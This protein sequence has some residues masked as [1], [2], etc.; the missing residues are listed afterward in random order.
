TPDAEALVFGEQRLSYAQL[1]ARANQ[2]AH[3]LIGQGVGPDVL[4]GIAAERSV[5]MVVGL[6]AILKAGGAYV[7]LDPEYPSERLSYMFED[8]GIALLLTQSHLQLPLPAGL[9]VLLLDQLALDGYPAHAPAVAVSP[10]NLAYVIYTSGSTGK[11][12]GAGNRHSALTNRLCWMQQ[13]YGLDGSDTVLQKTPFSFDVSVWEFFWPL[14]TG[15]RLAVAGPGDHRDPSRLVELINAH[16]VTTLHFVPSML[17]VFLQDAQVG[18]CTGLAR[19]V[20]SGEAL[21]VDA[22]QQV[23]AKLPQAGLYNLYGPTEAAID[24]THW[25]CRE[26]GADTVPIGQPIANLATYVLDAELNPVPVGVIGELYLGGAGLARGYHRRPALTAERFATSPF[27]SGERLYRTGDLARQR[28]DGVIEYAG[29]IDHQVKIR[30]LRIEL[31]EIEARLME[32]AQ[33]REAVVLALDI[34]GS[35]QL[36]GYLVPQDGVDTHNL[37]DTL[38]AS[39]LAQLPDYMVPSH[40][41]LLAELP[42]SPNG[43]LERKA[44]PRPDV[45]QA[46][47]AYVAPQT[48]LEHELAALWQEV[49]QVER[50]GTSDNFFELGGDSI[51]SIQLVSRARQAGIRFSPKALFE[52]P[53]IQALAQVAERGASAAVAEQGPLLGVTPLLPF[54]KV[55]FDTAIPERQHW[56]QS[57][58]LQPTEVLD[59]TMLQ[60]ALD[61]LV[62]QHDALR[63]RFT[64]VD[65]QWQANCDAPG[66]AASLTCVSLADLDALG[67]HADA[68]QRSLDLS[69]G[70]LFKALLATCGEAGQRLLLVAHHLVVDG[71]SWRI[72][73]EDLQQACRQ[74]AKGLAPG[75]AAR[76]TSVRGWAEY[77]QSHARDTQE[78]TLAHWRGLLEGRDGDLPQAR[79]GASLQRQLARSCVS[80]FDAELTRQLLQHAGSAYRTQVNDLLLTALAQVIARWT[81]REDVLVQLEGHGREVPSEAFDLSRTVGWFTSLYPVRLSVGADQPG[82]IKQVK[83]Q[84]RAL[85]GN[86]LDF[87]AA[88]YLGSA[89][90]REALAE[91]PVPRI[92]FNYLGQFDSSFAQQGGLFELA[93]EARGEELSALAPLGNWLSIDGG[94]QGG[95]L[96]LAWTFSAAMFDETTIAALASDY[97]RTLRL[98]VEHCLQP[99]VRGVTPSDFPLAGLDQAGLERLDLP[100]ARLDDLFPLSPMQQGMLFHTL[101]HKAAGDYI[102]QMRLDVEGL[103]PERFVQAWQCALDHHDSLRSG[104]LWQGEL[105]RP[106]QMVLRDCALPWRLIDWRGRDDLAT[107]LDSLAAAERAQG[108]VLDQAPLLR[109]VL[110]RTGNDRHQ[111]IY[112]CHHILMDGWSVS[113]LLAEVLQRYAGQPPQRSVG[114]YRDYIAWLQ[115]RDVQATETFWKAQ[116]RTLEAPTRL[117][118]VFGAASVQAA[119]VPQQSLQVPL[120]AS[121]S[122]QLQAFARSQQVTVNTLLQAAWLL[123]LQ[124]YTGQA[125]VCFGATVA[126]R[127]A[128]V[129]GAMEQIGLFINTL[130]VIASPR[131]Q[132]PVGEFLRALQ[133]SNLDLREHEHTPLYELQRWAGQGAQALFDSLLVF[134]NYPVSAALAE[135]SPQGP[136]FTLLANHEQTNYPLV[137]AVNLG[138][139]LHLQYSH[140]PQLFDGATVAQLNRHLLHLLTQLC[141][142]GARRLG[143]LNLLPVA[144]RDQLLHCWTPCAEGQPLVHQRI[145]QWA[146]ETPDAVALHAGDDTVTYGQLDARANALAHALLARGIKAEDRLGVAMPR[147]AELIV[148]LL[149]VHK[150]G[151]AYVPLDPEYPAERLAY[152]M[153]DS[154]MVLLLSDSRLQG[155]PVPDG[156]AVLHPD[157]LDLSALPCT[158]PAVAVLP[159]QLAYVIYT[160]GSTGQ[161]KGVAVE[162]GP[163]AMH[164]R[165]IGQRYEMT[166]EDC[167]LH[168]MSFAF[169]G[170]HERWLTSLTHGGRLLIRDD[171]LWTAQKTYEQMHRFG[172]SVAAFPPLYLLQLAEHAERDGNPPPVRVYCFGGDAVPNASF[173]LARRALRPRYII[174]GYGP[175]ET[176]VTPLIWKAGREDSCGAAYAPIGTRIGQRSAQVLDADLDLLPVGLPGE[177]Y[178]GGSGV[179]RGYLDRPGLTAERFVPDPFGDGARVYRSGDLVRQRSDGVVDYL[180]RIDHQVKIRG[181]RIE[182][183]EI[184]ASLQAQPLVRE[185]VVL[186]RDGGTGPQLVGYLLPEDSAALQPG[187]TQSEQREAIR[188][189]LKRQLPAYMVPSHLVFL[190]RFPLTPNGKLDRKGLPAPDSLQGSEAFQAPSSELQQQVAG[191]WQEVLKVE[192]VGLGDNFF[193]LGGHSLL[194]TQATAQ[195][196]LLLGGEVALELLFASASLADYAEAVAATLNTHSED[197]LSDMFD[198]M[199]ELEAN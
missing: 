149:A 152:L 176:V 38:K 4:V 55:F 191:V 32:Q 173:E 58:L 37:R 43:K 114:R 96:S 112:T 162:H 16:R 89:S 123:L 180:G 41:V 75:L 95:E 36:V 143:E 125:T 45:S 84:L 113:R 181:F 13:A 166:P 107:S 163:L 71:V 92:T 50:V 193:E 30:G 116:L 34:L 142:D 47:A 159:A 111:L 15:A 170:A 98:L 14:M 81:G 78:A 40:W 127:P 147:S 128:Q 182:L 101:Y 21:P 57:V 169:D 140:D 52:Q 17:Q 54:Q 106:L 137:L 27:G 12:K 126:G 44:L 199:A 156:L 5:E 23:F 124:R 29:R 56:N 185:A 85:P 183:G 100:L 79:V 76:S 35:Q 2:L 62:E 153:R 196:Q 117:A 134:E 104:F 51:V 87:A 28:A 93:R 49:L 80:R 63:L 110:V 150:A 179:A 69:E 105:E 198:F 11:P 120:D 135:A 97:E 139:T 33:V 77:L 8:S 83:E 167:E 148:C 99:G 122:A 144:E 146:R 177:L 157:R 189:A 161:P 190:E 115:E 59:A 53:T 94:V 88:R 184:E 60:Q 48:P 6:L 132:Q 109:L 154:A 68:L 25:T 131:P 46:Q 133:A 1:D 31:G 20:C 26:E 18:S 74:L 119:P 145:A 70:P 91:L 121:Y 64:E 186:A 187:A 73:L 72:L 86:G 178:L 67:S 175:T 168:F 129:K 195:L 155:L 19:I 108:F 103:D 174:N 24:V 151:A 118:D 164:C 10:E 3:C 65:G 82:S 192:R 165:A 39:L 90:V 138:Q 66:Q 171:S 188:L 158:A 160:S 197:D 22:Q 136:R 172:V 9:K 61:A 130:P 7:P 42:L 194:A 141:A 102:N